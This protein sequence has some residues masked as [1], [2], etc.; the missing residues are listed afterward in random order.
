MVILQNYKDDLII[1][2]TDLVL[3]NFWKKERKWDSF[4]TIWFIH[5]NSFYKANADFCRLFP[6]NNSCFWN[7]ISQYIGTPMKVKVDYFNSKD[8]KIFLLLLNAL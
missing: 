6:W 3:Y 8:I 7:V 1:Y 2:L 4:I 5:V